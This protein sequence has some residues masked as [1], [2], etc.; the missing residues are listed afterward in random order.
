MLASWKAK[1]LFKDEEKI[2]QNKQLN[3]K[4]SSWLLF[5]YIS[6]VEIFDY[7]NSLC[8]TDHILIDWFK[9]MCIKKD[10]KEKSKFSLGG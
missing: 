9:F 7:F 3:I 4:N 8:I 5:L 1:Q 6:F 10:W 2:H